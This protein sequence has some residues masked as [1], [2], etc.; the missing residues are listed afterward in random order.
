[1]GTGIDMLVIGNSILKKNHQ[2]ESLVEDYKHKYKQ[3]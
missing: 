3:D 2:N 1:M